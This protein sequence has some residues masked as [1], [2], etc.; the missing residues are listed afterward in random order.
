[1]T[2]QQETTNVTLND[3]NYFWTKSGVPCFMA[4][5]DDIQDVVQ[6]LGFNIYYLIC[7]VAEDKK[8][9]T[10]TYVNGKSQTTTSYVTNMKTK[11]VKVVNNFV[12][13]SITVVEDEEIYDFTPI[14]EIGEYNLPPIPRDIVTKLDEFFR[15]VDAQHGTE[16]IVILTFDPN[17]EDS[18]GWGVLVPE[19]TNTSVHC[20]YDPDSIVDQKPEH[21]MIVGSVHSHPGMPAYASGTDHADQADFDGIHITYGWQKSINNNATQYH[22]ELQMA[23]YSWTLKPDDVFESFVY[24]KSPDPQVVE[25]S[26]KVKKAYPPQGGSVSLVAHTPAHSL[27]QTPPRDFIPTGITSPLSKGTSTWESTNSPRVSQFNSRT[28]NYPNPHDDDDHIVIAEVQIESGGFA[29]C[30]SCNSEVAYFINTVPFYCD[31]CDMPLCF[32]NNAYS[33]II[34]SAEEY[35]KERNLKSNCN[36]YIWTKDD[37]DA[38]LLMRIKEKNYVSDSSDYISLDARVETLDE[39]YY[40]GFSHERLVCCDLPIEEISYC[41]CSTPVYYDDV[42]SFDVAHPHSVY[43][44][45][46]SCIEKEFYYSRNC[47]PYLQAIVDFAARDRVMDAKIT[48]C[49]DFIPYER[50]AVKYDFDRDYY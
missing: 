27:H 34:S 8:N 4:T 23:G 16:S 6:A 31:V 13:H 12:G 25:W 20:K 2:N 1:M 14:R 11:I 38:D 45:N 18:R 47:K 26:E 48:E 46:D 50:S 22:I 42:I 44:S 41:T 40:E 7:N 15:L 21:V 3:L 37:N 28:Q 39:Y 24:N 5:R 10:T 19:Q 33:E 17:F 32:P 30:P 9:E 35:L 29:S 36:Y 49:E 43:D